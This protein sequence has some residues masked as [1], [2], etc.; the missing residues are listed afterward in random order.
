MFLLAM[1]LGTVSVTKVAAQRERAGDIIVDCDS[2]ERTGVSVTVYSGNLALVKESRKVPL[3]AGR[4]QIRCT[5]FPRTIDSASVMVQFS[6]KSSEPVVLEQLYEYDVVNPQNLLESHI[7]EKVMLVEKS[8]ETLEEKRTEATLLSRGSP[9]VYRIGKDVYLGHPGIVAFPDVKTPLR[10]SPSLGWLVETSDAADQEIEVTYLAEGLSWN[11]DYNILF[12][13]DDSISELSAWITIDNHCGTDFP[14]ARVSVV[15]GE[16]A[17]KRKEQPLRDRNTMAM[18]AK[19]APAEA[20]SVEARPLFEYHFYPLPRPVSL[21]TNQ[22]RQVAFL[23]ARNVKARKELVFRSP[24][25]WGRGPYR[26][27][28]RRKAV[29]EIIINNKKEDGLGAPLPAGQVRMYKQAGAEGTQFIGEDSLDHTPEGAEVKLTAGMAFDVEMERKQ[30]KYE[31]LSKDL[32]QESWEIQLKNYKEHEVQ[33]RV[34]EPMYGDWKIAKSSYEWKQFDARTAE[35]TV[36][37]QAGGVAVL[38]YTA[39]FKQ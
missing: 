15:A 19:A 5:D 2:S 34:L 9:N 25:Y 27:V 28:E 4:A 26:D 37:I 23:T 32:I 8:R 38:S 21:F 24:R 10:L 18:M 1:L 36:S 6:S 35:F 20:Q 13:D 31:M 22:T 33:V 29:V 12:D 17:R 14:D 39:V 11:A 3:P 30:V 7:G 16:P